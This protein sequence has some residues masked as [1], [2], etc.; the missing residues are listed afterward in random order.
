VN[1]RL[2]IVGGGLASARVAQGYREAG[3]GDAIT[4]VSADQFLPYH[5]PPLSKK[6][7][8]G[9]AEREETFVHPQGWYREQ[10]VG[11][12]L[13]TYAE[14]VDG[15]ELVLEGGERLGFDR[16]VLATGARPRRF[17]WPGEDLDGVHTLRT[18]VDSAL[19]REQARD[20]G[21]AVVVGAGFIGCEVTASL[22][23][24][25][26]DVVHVAPEEGPYA[27]FGSSA[28]T[29]ALID[30][31]RSKG[32][33]VRYGR[34]VRELLGEGHV[35][36]V[37]TSEG[38]ELQARIAVLGLGVVPNTELAETAG[39][40]IGDGVLVDERFETSVPGI[41]AVGDLA[42]QLDPVFGRRRRIEHWSH[43]NVV[44]AVLGKILA[45]EDVRHDA[46]STF[47]T[48]VFGLGIWVL[49]DTTHAEVVRVEGDFQQQSAIA[50][51]AEDGK[52]AAVSCVGQDAD[53]REA[54]KERIRRHEPLE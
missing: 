25:G 8:R 7:L 6:F 24:L 26:V 32:V 42:N 20:A 17:G 41:Y 29:E 13:E 4:L 22:H 34:G 28:L 54:L 3:G 27:A 9:E 33:E 52:L 15:K 48:E 18:L 40:E 21:S 50:Y 5:R 47:F 23:A 49:G 14:R 35:D 45:G 1:D 16:L 2:V 30:L 12:R 19:I 46:V 11:L 51:Y 31:Y 39:A 10:S 38:E 37:V 44:G 43:A 53:T 36:A